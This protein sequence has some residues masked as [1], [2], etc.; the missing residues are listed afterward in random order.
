MMINSIQIA[1]KCYRQ[2]HQKLN[3][4]MKLK[5]QLNKMGINVQHPNHLIVERKPRTPV[6]MPKEN[7]T[8]IE[9]ER[10]KYI[11][12]PILLS[13]LHVPTRYL[14]IQKYKRQWIRPGR[15]TLA[16]TPKKSPKLKTPVRS[17]KQ[18]SLR[19]INEMIETISPPRFTSPSPIKSPP[20]A[21]ISERPQI[22]EAV[23]AEVKKV[24]YDNIKEAKECK[25]SINKN[26]LK[27][28]EIINGMIDT[29]HGETLTKFL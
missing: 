24:F 5:T 3:E 13:E 4:A 7:L 11:K 18:P 23:L 27:M 21:K 6:P 14:P 26:M 29:C 19:D 2:K 25:D 22:P 17:P 10:R 20:K 1:K 28:H 12:E 15:S 16:L 8:D 9:R